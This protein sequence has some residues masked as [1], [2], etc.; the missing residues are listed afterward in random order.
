MGN[1]RREHKLSAQAVKHAKPGKLSDG[2]GL[3]LITKPTG[4]QSWVLRTVVDGKPTDRGLGR[5]PTV[6]L[7]EARAAAA[8][9]RATGE[10]TAPV[11]TF[12]ETAEAVHALL[13]P[14]WRNA[15]TSREWWGRF[16]KYAG[17]LM[18][19]K[20]TEITRRDVL[21]VLLPIW[22]TKT[23]TAKLLRGQIR[24]VLAYAMAD[25]ETMAG[26]AA[27]EALDGALIAQPCRPKHRRAIQHSEV[28]EALAIVDRGAAFDALRLCL[29]FVVYTAVRSIEAREA[30]WGEIDL[31][32]AV[33]SIPAQRM[34]AGRPHKV[35][36]SAQAVA[37]L[38]EARKLGN[39]TGLVFPSPYASDK[40]V[41]VVGLLRVLETNGI[42]STVHGFRTSFRQWAL[43]QPGTSFAAA[44]LA[45]AHTLGGPVAQSYLRDA[46]LLAQRRV[47]MQ[48][49]GDYIG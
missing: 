7:A 40:P 26:N 46:D 19:R 8:T 44:E 9:M 28:S 32:A 25:N 5:Y 48:A 1:T 18:A 31:Q 34:K 37:V 29:R 45:L 36:L 39:G 43:E 24:K 21:D 14:T 33:W 20:V 35:P 30:D 17:P 10:R 23:T 49:W 38:A 15:R 4:R 3:S 11:P 47:L 42:D 22:S 2:G 6:T 16:D 41:S 13:R 27:G 12:R